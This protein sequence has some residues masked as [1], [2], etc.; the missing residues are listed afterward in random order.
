MSESRL[1]KG[2]VSLKG[3]RK[4]RSASRAKTRDTITVDTT[5]FNSLSNGLTQDKTARNQSLT[6]GDNKIMNHQHS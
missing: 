1:K 6:P 5:N 3:R 2:F 4:K